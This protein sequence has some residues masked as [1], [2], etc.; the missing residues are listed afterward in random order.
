MKLTILTIAA[1]LALVT[2]AVADQFGR[3]TENVSA[4]AS[5]SHNFS[6]NANTLLA[7]AGAAY[8]FGDIKVYGNTNYNATTSTWNGFNVGATTDFS[9][10]LY[11][12]I[13][14]NYNT[15][16][17]VVTAEVGVKF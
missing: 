5:Y 13:W 4:S 10:N 17:T 7:T 15:G 16:T 11:G 2:P 12:D 1:A 8:S 6:T 3:S 9:E 14:A